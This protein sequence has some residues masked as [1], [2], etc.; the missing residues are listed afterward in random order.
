MSQKWK[1][2]GN[3]AFKSG[4]FP[5]ALKN[6]KLVTEYLEMDMKDSEEARNMRVLCLGNCAL[7]YFKSKDNKQAVAFA[8]M[9][10][11]N[12]K[13]NVKALFR[14]GQAFGAMGELGQAQESLELALA[15]E[16]GNTGV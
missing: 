5:K 4:D 14:K 9:V 1:E 8:D 3:T 11:E 10:L 13:S 6:Y 16:P 7:V 2:Q 15:A 12:D